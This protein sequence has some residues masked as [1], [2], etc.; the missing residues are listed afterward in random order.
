M[1]PLLEGTSTTL[2]VVKLLL[3]SAHRTGFDVLRVW[4]DGHGL[5][6]LGAEAAVRLLRAHVVAVD[7]PAW[8]EDTHRSEVA[9]GWRLGVMKGERL[10]GGHEVFSL[11]YRRKVF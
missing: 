10:S 2:K 9:T 3:L 11:C 5:S 7:A 6:A 4:V 8:V 1:F